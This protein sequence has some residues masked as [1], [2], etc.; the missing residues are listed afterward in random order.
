[1]NQSDPLIL[2]FAL[3]Q[4]ARHEDRPATVTA[5]SR[6]IE[7]RAQL[8][9]R[10]PDIAHQLQRWGE[11]EKAIEALALWR[12]QGAP[13]GHAEHEQ[14]VLL[15]RIGRSEEAA[16]LLANTPKD[17]P[18]AF[19][20]AYL[21]GAIATNLNDMKEAE[22]ELRRTIKENRTA[23]RAWLALA[24][25]G[26]VTKSDE[27]EILHVLEH[28]DNMEQTDK[29]AF[30]H[31]L[32]VLNHQRNEYAAAF[33]WF[34]RCRRTLSQHFQYQA[35]DNIASANIVKKWTD[36]DLKTLS[37]DLS[38]DHRHPIFVTGLPRS[39]TT[40]VEQ[41]LSAHTKVDGGGELGL[42]IQLEATSDGFSPDDLRRY[43]HKGGSHE[44]LR[45]LYLRLAQEHVSGTGL[46]VDKS[47]N[48]SRSLGPLSILFPEA[49]IIW[50]R[51]DPLDNAWSI[52]RAWLAN[53]VVGGWSL[54]DLAHHMRIED[55]LFAHWKERIGE[56]LLEVPFESLVRNPED[57]IDR[58]N[59]HCG[60][61]TE[62]LQ[63]TP[64]LA[65]R[66]VTTASAQQ[67]REPIN[68]KGLGV[69]LPYDK[70]LY[71]FKQAYFRAENVEES[72]S[73]LKSVH[74]TKQEVSQSPTLPSV[75]P[76]ANPDD[77]Q[78]EPRTL[79]LELKQALSQ[80]NRA[81]I[82]NIIAALVSM[83]AKLGQQW[84]SLAQVASHNCEFTLMRSVLERW[85]ADIGRTPL[86]L[87]E[88]ARLEALA[89]DPQ[90]AWD[91]VQ[92]IDENAVNKLAINY[93]KGTLS[94]SL[95]KIDQGVDHLRRATRI[96]PSS[97]QSWL[98]LMMT[99]KVSSEDEQFFSS[100][101]E[102]IGRE[103]LNEQATF[104]AAKGRLLERKKQYEEAFGSYNKAGL[105]M[106]QVSEYNSSAD[107]DEAKRQMAYDAE[108]INRLSA[109][110]SRLP[111]GRPIFVTG[112]PRSGTTLVE[113]ILTAHSSVAGGAELNL[114]RLVTQ[115]MGGFSRERVENYFSLHGDLTKPRALHD[116]LLEER[117]P[118]PGLI[119]DKSL[120]LSRTLGLMAILYPKAPIV[121]M[122]RNPADCAWS[123]FRTFFIRSVD[124]S[125]HLEDIANH[126][127]FEDQLYEHW[128]T[129]LKDRIL[130]VPYA[131]LIDDPEAWITRITEHCGLDVE[132][133]QFESHKVKRTVSTASAVQVREPI[134]RKGLATAAPYRD[135]MKPFFDGYKGEA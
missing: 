31:T 106:S 81:R 52:Y 98:A 112:L 115:E 53:N 74:T 113:Q 9:S 105:I 50:L 61:E 47:L 15:A 14:A 26:S 96:S 82:N 89:G 117:F 125:W 134:N 66:S 2:L 13:A 75:K 27:R 76:V 7:D 109:D 86:V 72:S 59:K 55:E 130:V 38:G 4:A 77:L 8:G 32:G 99:G 83:R 78:L 90:C 121:W 129:V 36:D 95:G 123:A 128:S 126:F 24:Q 3:Q 29:A 12:D 45:N 65:K 18:T 21:K 116:H 39:G 133:A 102:G 67:V 97:G 6:L 30:Q 42:A 122:R 68:L 34:E 48:Q 111:A 57:W 131:D 22:R 79:L 127:N 84:Q 94:I 40:L 114:M 33:E 37:S 107:G 60:L 91:L 19:G 41:I 62:P 103:A 56:R 16:Q 135:L 10:W 88:R 58:I 49:Q 11:V 119:I 69:A 118:E 17:Q 35:D 124:W 23:G 87:V 120:N 132:P 108:I 46:F 85:Q 5:A 64:H 28:H 110:I 93:L 71:P 92:S 80:R 70:W 1:M 43:F 73:N 100:A 25:I 54:S 44:Y 63:L 20:N 101:E 104:F 51:R